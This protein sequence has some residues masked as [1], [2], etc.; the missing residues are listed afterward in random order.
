MLMRLARWLRLA[1]LDVI[2]DES[3]AALNCSNAL[4]PK[5]ESC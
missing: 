4:A 5:T 3:I 2:A 1:G